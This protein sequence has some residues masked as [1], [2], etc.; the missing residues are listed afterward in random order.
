MCLERGFHNSITPYPLTWPQP[1]HLRLGSI[2]SH[3]LT[4][5]L[6]QNTHKQL[7]RSGR[8]LPAGAP[9]GSPRD[10]GPGLPAPPGARPAV[11]AR[12]LLPPP[13]LRPASPPGPRRCWRWRPPVPAQHGTRSHS[14]R[15]WACHLLGYRDCCISPTRCRKHGPATPW[16]L[17]CAVVVTLQQLAGV[18]FVL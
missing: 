6:M 9:P 2:V 4:H 10:G 15:V 18:W 12:P 1:Q 11:P 17:T 3:P 7:Q 14:S 13:A 8:C 5:S 16:W